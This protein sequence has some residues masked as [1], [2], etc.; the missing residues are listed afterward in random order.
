MRDMKRSIE[1]AGFDEDRGHHPFAFGLLAGAALGVGAGLLLAPTKGAEARK[2]VGKQLT[3]M[4][5]VCASGFTRAKD[6]AGGWAHKGRDAYGS[7]RTFVARG[8]RETGR[9]MREVADA[10]TMKSR[11]ASEP[12]RQSESGLKVEGIGGSAREQTRQSR[13]TA[14]AH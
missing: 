12:A 1:T 9:Y 7:S 13:F 14:H 10:V 4:K 11:R 6:I 8:A 5:G 2:Q 3:N